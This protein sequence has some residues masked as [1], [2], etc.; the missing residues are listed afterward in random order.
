MNLSSEQRAAGKAK[1]QSTVGLNRRDF[2]KGGIVA[3]AVSGAGLGAMYFGYEKTVSSPLRGRFYRHGRRRQR[4]A[5]C[6]HA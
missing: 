4:A 1:F 6:D 5:Q 3:G 2:L